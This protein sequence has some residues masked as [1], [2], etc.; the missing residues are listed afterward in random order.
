MKYS[1]SS[2]RRALLGLLVRYPRAVCSLIGGVGVLYAMS[3]FVAT[4]F[5][6]AYMCYYTLYIT[7]AVACGTISWLQTPVLKLVQCI[8][9]A[10]LT[11]VQYVKVS[12]WVHRGCKFVHGTV[13]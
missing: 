7:R 13:H 11:T 3:G 1:M 12:D 5:H 4:L 9:Y 8:G 2:Y 6:I 10:A